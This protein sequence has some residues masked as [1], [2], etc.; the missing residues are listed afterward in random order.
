MN[1]HLVPLDRGI[2]SAVGMF[3]IA[4]PVLDLPTYPYNLF[5]IVL[6]A[7]ALA[8]YCPLYAAVRGLFAKPGAAA[9]AGARGALPRPPATAR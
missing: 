9:G 8:G 7:T 1:T 6:V 3:L 5:G 2:R 4:T